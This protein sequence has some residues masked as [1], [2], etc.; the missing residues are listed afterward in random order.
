MKEKSMSNLND[1][2]LRLAIRKA[3]LTRADRRLYH[4][5]LKHRFPWATLKE[6]DTAV[7]E[8]LHEGLLTKEKG[9]SGAVVYLWH[10]E[11]VR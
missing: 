1:M 9:G 11:L 3:A 5:A 7:G 2:R 10:E 8:L 4:S 6:I